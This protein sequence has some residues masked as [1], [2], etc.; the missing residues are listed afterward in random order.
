[1]TLASSRLHL[2]HRRPLKRTS[3]DGFTRP[4]LHFICMTSPAPSRHLIPL[5]GAL[6]AFSPLA[7]DMYLPAFPRIARDLGVRVGLVGLTLSVFLV[8]LAVG[9]LLCGPLADRL[10]RRTPLLAGCALFTA[11]AVVCALGRSVE[12][13]I[14][15]RFLMGIG[16]AT[17]LAISRAVVRD[18]FDE[19][20]SARTYSM[21]MI[22]TG[23]APIIAPALGSLMLTYLHW[24]AIFWLLAAFGVA[25]IAMVALALPE[26]LPPDRRV[27]GRL[28]DV[29]R[30]YLAIL[31]D[32]RFLG[33]GLVLGFA[34][35]LLF[36]YLAGSP[37]VFI[38]LFGLS[39]GRYSLLFATNSIGLFVGGRLNHHLVGRHSARTILRRACAASAASGIVLVLLAVTKVGGLP[40]FFAALFVTVATLGLIMPNA[41]AAAMAPFAAQAGTASALLGVLQYALG[42]A[43][44]A[45]VG[46]LNNG[47]ALPMTALIAT[48][49]ALATITVHLL[50]RGDAPP[51]VPT[52]RDELDAEPA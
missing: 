7:I 49:A 8:G 28:G 2:I 3:A 27:H 10:G 50:P 23:I 41:T 5:L 43:S 37:F 14:A 34:Y 13:L 4:R 18:L 25:S 9:Q 19:T 1:M 39:P 22:V 12:T 26:T 38:D 29:A 15:S 40:L 21:M 36:A 6:C 11:T 16:G 24:R 30:R 33:F 31:T 44:G 46:L 47:T 52:A 51:V 48:A 35:G 17:G 42:A 32:P 45:L 20:A